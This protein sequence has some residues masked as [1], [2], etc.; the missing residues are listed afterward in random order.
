MAAFCSY[1]S[2]YAFRKPFAAASYSEV[3]AVSA[4]GLVVQYKTVLIIAQVLG[5]CVSK[6]LGIKFVSEMPAT[7]RALSIGGC[8]AVAWVALLLFALVP[9][10]WNI[11]C[12][13]LNGLPLGMVWGLVFGFLEGRRVSEVL[14]IGLS[15]SYILASGVVKSVGKS[16]INMGVPEFW[17][18]FA[19]GACFVVPMLV[20]VFLLA[21]IP[22]PT[23]EDRAAR[24]ERAPMDA[25]ARREFFL[26][27]LPGLLPLTLLYILLTAFRDFRD[28]FA[29]ELWEALGFDQQESAAL[30]AGSEVPVTLGVLGVLALLMFIHDNRKALLWVHVIMLGGTALVGVSTLAYQGGMIGPVAWMTLIGLGLY[31]A[32]VPFGCIL[33]DRLIATVGA[34]ATAGFLIYVTDA[35]GYLGS[36]VLMLY[37]DLANPNLSWLE[38]FISASY[39]TSL[40]CSC[41]LVVS[42]FYFRKL[43]SEPAAAGGVQ[44]LLEVPLK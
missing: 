41:G 18:P 37:K 7:R 42:L 24:T 26:T 3:A 27:Y 33:F 31:A 2:M 21:S 14:G 4:F 19:T 12:L 29:T 44:R 28:N 38:F 16:M 8:I 34:V 25:R 1:F 9:A 11:L 32:Y 6:F 43:T 36:V 22:P 20:F 39:V 35:F 17:M 23:P 40:F 15:A 10:P 5:Y 30:L 13:V